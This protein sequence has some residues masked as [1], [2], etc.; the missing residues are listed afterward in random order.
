MPK[1]MIGLRHYNDCKESLYP[2][3]KEMLLNIL[4]DKLHRQFGIKF[5]GFD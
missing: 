3:F 1:T 4:S 2:N 5:G